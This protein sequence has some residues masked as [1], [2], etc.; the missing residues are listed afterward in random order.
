M[1]EI[2]PSIEQQ[3]G[4]KP[5]TGSKPAVGGLC[6]EIPAP[7]AAIVVFGASGDLTRRK[8]LLSVFQIFTQDLLN[9]KFY[10]LGCG[11][12]KLSD[13]DFR[14]LAQQVIRENIGDVS[15]KDLKSFT[16]KLYYIDGDYA[17]AAFYKRIKARI[18]ELDKKH[19]VQDNL[20]FYLAVPPFLYTTIVNLLGSA[21]L[22]CPE[23]LDAKKQARLIVEKPF[24]RDLKSAIELNNNISRCFNESQIYRIDHYLGKETVQNILIFRFANTI[25]EPVWNRNFVDSVQITIAE[26]LGVEHRAGYY[27]KAGALRDIFQNHTLSMLTLVAM[28]PPAS[29]EADHIRDEKVKLLRSI[30]P[31]V[32]EEVKD[33]F[34]R[35]QYGPGQIDNTQVPG[36]RAE[37]GID[38]QSKTETFVAAK[39]F[40][41]NWRWKD[42]PFYLRTGKRLAKKDT[43]IAIIFKKVPHSMFVSSGL[44][45]LPPNVLVLHIQPDEGLS[46][47]FQAKRPGSK[48]CIGT[49]NMNFCY[50]SVFGVAMPEAYHRL[51]LDC[52]LGDQTLFT[53]NDDVEI[54]WKL[55]TP[56]L[57]DWEKEDSAPYIYPAGSESFIEADRLIEADGRKWSKLGDLTPK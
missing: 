23:R 54:A 17:D 13:E 39:L 41:D 50:R 1:Q 56:V 36:Y 7:P 43:E 52:M 47:S 26:T 15:A 16:E 18:A 6:A 25:F 42:V 8:L 44:D 12:K 49:L 14:R 48:I 2:R 33:V 40:I 38:P 53:R 24:G 9:E 19:K 34:V 51:L 37:P 57:E 22:S 27:D 35:G 21:G 46:L 28:E 10:L 20:L 5:W 29:F 4:A 55:L 32:T 11:R 45:D 30:R 31:L 3:A